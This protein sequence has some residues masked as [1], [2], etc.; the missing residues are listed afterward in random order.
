MFGKQWLQPAFSG[1]TPCPRH[2]HG[3][4]KVD[5]KNILLFGGWTRLLIHLSCD[6]YYFVLIQHFRGFSNGEIKDQYYNDVYTLNMGKRNRIE[7]VLLGFPI[8]RL[9]LRKTFLCTILGAK[10]KEAINWRLIYLHI[11]IAFLSVKRRE[12]DPELVVLLTWL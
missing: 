7:A 5:R 10:F 3:M 9:L 1:P 6:I 11:Y 2:S 8:A 12:K 4:H